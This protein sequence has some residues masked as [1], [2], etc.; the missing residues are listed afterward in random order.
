MKLTN[1]DI[2]EGILNASSKSK[3][4]DL[5]L[6]ANIW[7]HELKQKGMQKISVQEFLA[8]F[9]DGQFSNPESIRRSRQ[10]LQEEKPEYRG[11]K[12]RERHKQQDNVKYQLGY[13]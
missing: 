3:N 10:K 4:N 2:I 5:S 11:E 12:Y 9:A 8:M 1:Q 7:W 13:Y 6:I